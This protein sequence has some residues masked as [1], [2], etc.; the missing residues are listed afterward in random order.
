MLPLLVVPVVLPAL[1]AAV[2]GSTLVLHSSWAGMSQW[3]ELLGDFRCRVRDGGD[4]DLRDP[5]RRVAG[6]SVG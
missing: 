6:C 2:S 5:V 4:P 1:L 3:I